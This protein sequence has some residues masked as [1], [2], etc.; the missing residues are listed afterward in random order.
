MP[1]FTSVFPT[2]TAHFESAYFD[3]YNFT[4]KI[5]LFSF[6]FLSTLFIYTSPLPHF[7][8]VKIL[9]LS[10]LS[11]IT[12]LILSILFKL[13]QFIPDKKYTNIN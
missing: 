11:L 10:S 12:S 7:L 2:F 3:G 6:G 9:G 4:T 8:H 1:K 13:I 5:S